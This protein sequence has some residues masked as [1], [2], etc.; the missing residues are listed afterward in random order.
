M[1]IAPSFVV[2]VAV[3]ILVLA[4]VIAV[5]R[6]HTRNHRVRSALDLPQRMGS[7]QKG[8]PMQRIVEAFAHTDANLR[9]RAPHLS[10]PE[11]HEMARALM[12][13]RGLLPE[14]P[15]VRGSGATESTPQ[16]VAR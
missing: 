8:V 2:A 15:P 7:P 16:A 4:N 6:A 11:R 10:N 13:A 5:Y 1:P 9:K 3:A 12:R 14:T